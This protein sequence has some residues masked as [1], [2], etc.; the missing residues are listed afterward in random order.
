MLDPKLKVE[1][2]LL[3][4]LSLE[5]EATEQQYD[6]L[7]HLLISNQDAIDY[8]IELIEVHH[9]LQTCNWQVEHQ[10][11]CSLQ[12]ALE[13][14]AAYEQVAPELIIPEDKPQQVLID[15]VIYPPRE[16]R[17]NS[18]LSICFLVMSA[19]AMLLFVLFIRFAPPNGGIE[20]ATLTDSVNAKWGDSAASLEKGA[21]IT[22][23]NERLLLRQGYAELL[24]DTDARV[25][26]E[27]PTEIQILAEDRIGLN[28]GKVYAWVPKEALG[29]SVYTQNAKI[30]DM[31]TEFGVETEF[32]GD[33]RLHV[34]K[35]K[36]VL[37][38]GRKSDKTGI[39]VQKGQA[40]KV[41]AVSSEISDISCDSHLFV[42]TIDSEVGVVWRG[43]HQIDLAD[44][45]GGGNGFGTGK[46]GTR[47]DPMSGKLTTDAPGRRG[48]ANDYHLVPS[49]P[50]IDGV[51]IPNGRTQQ[52]VSSEGHL[53]QE[54]PVTSGLCCDNICY[55]LRSPDLLT[56][57]DPAASVS[58]GVPTLLIHAN[59]GITY[60]LQAIRELLPDAKVVRFQSKVGI[61]GAARPSVS[62]ADFWVLVD[63]KLRYQQ[64]QVKVNEYYTVDIELSEDDR[65]LTLVETDGGD[66]E[67]RIVDGLVV[68]AIDSDWGI[69][70]NPVLILE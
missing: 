48:S 33:T 16:N 3:I 21:R 7:N 1:L 13:E 5:G 45:I 53:F 17:K 2:R 9:S 62:N 18:K 55:E 51:F 40:K 4:N 68:P 10:L 8:Y 59:M 19:A 12:S 27:A 47:I 14:L 49:S 30:V 34:I 32:G 22:T 54:C 39:E 25:V 61:R 60:D 65:F 64:R 56:T 42:R 43:Q 63:G 37:I 36:T 23:G 29:F 15:K 57:Q 69:F 6:R 58:S 35:G 50:Y 38:A 31:G 66:P 11:L 26:I 28:Y 20:V 70:A 67:G 44:I 46:A 52:I 41:S 24:F